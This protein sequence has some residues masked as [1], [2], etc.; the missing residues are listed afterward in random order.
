MNEKYHP[1]KDAAMIGD[2]GY[3][4]IENDHYN[5][6]PENLA[7]L[8]QHV[9]I[10]KNVWEPAVGLGNLAT[11]LHEDGHTVW[12][13]DVKD[14]G[15]DERFILR[16]F[17][18][19][20]VL[21]DESIRA[22]VTN[23]PYETID[24]GTERWKHLQP[25]AESYG[26]SAKRVSLAELFCRHA[27]QV[28]KK[29]RGQVAMYLRNEFDCSKK[30]MSLVNQAPFA[31]KVVVTKRPRWIEGSTGSPRHNYSWFVW[32]WRVKTGGGLIRYSHPDF[33]KKAK[34]K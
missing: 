6:P 34:T 10:H 28:M 23:P 22:I 14:Y 12:S 21:P 4:R 1:K 31:G 32:D 26:M 2:S 15:F 5:T 27:I 20:D 8:T 33:A 7:C 16:D 3:D 29:N 25:L 9:E 30:R 24:L 11:A 13:S 18:D 19:T 17:L